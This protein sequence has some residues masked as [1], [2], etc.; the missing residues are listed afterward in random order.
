MTNENDIATIIKYTREIETILKNK[1]QAKGTGLHSLLSSV[2]FNFPNDLIKK[3]RYLASIRNE[4]MHN[5]SAK[6][7]IKSFEKI[8]TVSIKKLNKIRCVTSKASDTIPKNLK[9]SD[10]KVSKETKNLKKSDKKV[11]KETKNLKKLKKIKKPSLSYLEM[12]ANEEA[13]SYSGERNSND[14]DRSKNSSSKKRSFGISFKLVFLFIV[15]GA[16]FYDYQYNE[17]RQ[18]NKITQI[19]KELLEELDKGTL[20]TKEHEKKE[21]NGNVIIMENNRIYSSD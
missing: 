13:S 4:T 8:A 18:I 6:V 15:L 17:S 5:H 1:C 21:L 7:D 12:R 2:E 16:L 3:I 19:S 10:K 20:K 14:Y 9:K 11:S